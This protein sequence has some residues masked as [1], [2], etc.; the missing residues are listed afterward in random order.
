MKSSGTSSGGAATGSFVRASDGSYTFNYSPTSASESQIKSIM[1]ATSQFGTSGSGSFVIGKD[2]SY[3]FDYTPN[4]DYDKMNHAM[5]AAINPGWIRVEPVSLYAAPRPT[6]IQV[7]RE[8][9]VSLYAAPTPRPSSGADLSISKAKIEENITVLKRATKTIQEAWQ[10]NTKTNL[11]TIENS[12]AGPD[13]EAYIN[14]VNAMDKKVNNAISALELLTKTY[15]TALDRINE[16]QT[17]VMNI[18]NK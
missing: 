3:S 13:C 7:I 14:N 6:P 10:S 18:I 12:W 2:G 17:S 4:I 16:S 8:E 15:Q 9:P 1:N 11:T 5:Y